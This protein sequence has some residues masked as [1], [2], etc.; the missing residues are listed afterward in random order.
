MVAAA[1]LAGGASRRMGRDKATSW[2]S[3]GSRWPRWPW[4]PP[5]GSTRWWCW[6]PPAT[7]PA[8]WPPAW[9]PTRGRGRWPP[10]RCARL[11]D[12]GHVLVLAG[13]HPGLRVELLAHLTGLAGRGQ[14]RPAGAA[15]WPGAAGRG[16]RAGP[17]AGRRPGPAGRPGRRPLALGL[18]ATRPVVVEE[19]VWRT[20]TRTAA[21]SSTST[22]R[23]TWPPGTRQRREPAFGRRS[24]GLRPRDCWS[25]WRTCHGPG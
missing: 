3:A 24:T 8:G 14:A 25:G 13:D 17:G 12:T 21:P 4:P 10:W 9:S 11:L 15:P 5:P 1:V 18:L 7:R 2:P 19:P 22:T 20:S 6:S 23:P 16:V